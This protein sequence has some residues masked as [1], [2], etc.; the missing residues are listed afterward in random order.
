MKPRADE[1]GVEIELLLDRN[2]PLVALDPDA[3]HTCLANAVTNAIDACADPQPPVQGKKVCME[4]AS[5]SAR[6]HPL[7][8]HG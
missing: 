3:I 4:T 5:D 6:Q 1:Y 8:Y 2:L 7:P